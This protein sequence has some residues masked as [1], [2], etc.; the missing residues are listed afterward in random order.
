M[1]T[2]TIHRTRLWPQCYVATIQA[3]DIWDALT[4]AK[5]SGILNP[6]VGEFK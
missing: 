5:Q 3:K 6:I 2:F 4:I 1:K